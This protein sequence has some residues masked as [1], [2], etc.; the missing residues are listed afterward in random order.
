MWGRDYV[1]ACVCV[2]GGKGG[3]GGRGSGIGYN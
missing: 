2:F 1:R 3:K